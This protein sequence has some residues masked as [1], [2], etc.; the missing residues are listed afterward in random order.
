M[1]REQRLVF[2]EVADVYDR[3]RPAYPASL[4][5]EVIRYAS[6]ASGDPVLEVGCGTGKA[7]VPFATRDL[8][9]LALEP[10]E[11]MAAVAR[12]NCE[13]LDVSVETVAFED[14]RVSPGSFRLVYAAQAWHWVRPDVR[15]SQAHDVLVEDGTLA[16]FWN[17]PDWP[18]TPLRQAIDAVYAHIAPGLGARTPG[19]SAQDVGRRAC[20]DELEASTLF[21]DVSFSEHPWSTSYDTA[22]Y[23]E[24]L[25][26]QSDHR[27]L[28]REQRARLFRGVGDAIDAEGGT[29]PVAY[30]ADL[31]LARRAG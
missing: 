2:G 18:D 9:V 22:R 5:D 15:L 24:L 19:R 13:E 1:A 29:I 25:D 10:D 17:R 6:L 4:V 14:W 30:F 28:G 23:L 3:A 21:G 12:R 20:T 8:R 26:T 16:L 31:Y 7:T 11:N 27:L